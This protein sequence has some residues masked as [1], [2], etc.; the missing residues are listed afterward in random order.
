MSSVSLFGL[1]IR[2]PTKL[3]VLALGLLLAPAFVAGSAQ[4]A[5]SSSLWSSQLWA[6]EGDAAARELERLRFDLKK[7]GMH[8]LIELVAMGSNP[9]KAATIRAAKERLT[10]DF[11]REHQNQRNVDKLIQEI[12]R[13]D[14]EAGRLKI[15]ELKMDSWYKGNMRD[16]FRIKEVV[17][18]R[19]PLNNGYTP[20]VREG[21]L[22][23]VGSLE[24]R[25][26]HSMT[27]LRDYL[28]N[29]FTNTALDH[30]V[31]GKHPVEVHMGNVSETLSSLQG[32][33]Y[34]LVGEVTSSQGNYERLFMAKSPSGQVT[35]AITGINGLDRVRH[36]SSLMRYANNGQGVAPENMKIFGDINALKEANY[37]SFRTAL[38]SLG[39]PGK[40]A[41][42]GFRGTMRADLENRA[43]GQSAMEHLVDVLGANP[44]DGL[45]TRLQAERNAAPEAERA[46]FD[47]LIESIK[48]S[49]ALKSGLSLSGQEVF[50]KAENL[51]RFHEAERELVRMAQENPQSKIL[52]ELVADRALKLRGGRSA[53]SY[54]VSRALEHGEFRAEELTVRTNKGQ[55]SLKLINNYYGD[56]MGDMARAL[57]DA[58]YKKVG[59][60][61]TAGGL[62]EGVKIGDVHVPDRIYDHSGK[63]VGEGLN[64]DLI[65]Q[66]ERTG[67]GSL[68]ESIKTGVKLANV[69]SPTQETMKWLSDSRRAGMASVEVENAYLAEEIQRYNRGVSAAEKV[70]FMSSV[71]ISDVPGSE[72]TLGNNNGSTKGKFERMVDH[73]IEAFGIESVELMESE[74]ANKADQR[75]GRN[76][77][78]RK[79]YELAERLMGD[80]AEKSVMR[81]A[82]VAASLQEILTADQ[83]SRA[84]QANLALESLGLTAEQRKLLERQLASRY[85]DRD[86]LENLKRT[87]AVLSKAVAEMHAKHPQ[88]QFELRLGGGIE[89]GRFAPNTGLV[90]ELTG[91]ELGRKQ[92][93]EI[94]KKHAATYG[95]LAPKI[96][97]G[98]VG[99][100]AV[101]VGNGR[102]LLV[103]YGALKHIHADLL[104]S[105]RGVNLHV[106]P[107]GGRVALSYASRFPQTPES[108]QTAK[109]PA[110]LKEIR[111]L[112]ERLSRRGSALEMVKPTDARLK[113]EA[114]RT[115]IDSRGQVKLLVAEGQSLSASRRV[116]E[117]SRVMTF[118]DLITR[119]GLTRT[120]N[121]LDAARNGDPVA[122]SRLQ[123]ADL[124]TQRALLNELPHNSPERAEL[125]RSK[126][127]LENRADPYALL[128]NKRG[129]VNWDKVKSFSKNHGLGV[130]SF[131]LGLFL[132][133]LAKAV[134]S[135]DRATIEAFFD[136]LTHTDFWASYAVFSIGAEVGSAFYGKYLQRFV[137][138][139]FVSNV[140]RANVALASGMLISEL[141]MGHFN[142]KTFAINATG[143]MLSS[144]AVKVGLEG[145]KWVH[146]LKRMKNARRLVTALRLGSAPGWIYSGV[147]TAVVLFFGEKI[148]R[149][150]TRLWDR[151]Q[152]SKRLRERIKDFVIASKKARSTDDPALKAALEE[153]SSAFSAFR[154]AELADA[155]LAGEELQRELAELGTEAMG[156]ENGFVRMDKI[157]AAD[158]SKFEHLRANVERMRRDHDI[159]MNKQAK[160][161]MSRF[162][163]AY[164]EGL[165][166]AYEENQRGRVYRASKFDT[167]SRNRPESFDD[168]AAI[169]EYAASLTSSSSVRTFLRD[170]AA[171]VR[172]VK[173]KDRELL[174]TSKGA[175]R[176]IGD[177]GR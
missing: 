89:L 29:R 41:L 3:L 6:Q 62:A 146:N 139:T 135:G 109:V 175:S 9:D 133:E 12:F 71:M 160:A 84:L 17:A 150:I 67:A 104:L 165:R 46:K 2:R 147:E 169:Y 105:R 158:P 123:R 16:A 68:G 63:R 132:M 80:K 118:Q 110:E 28:A 152:L 119:D 7:E 128:R 82:N 122:N 117:L 137:K 52:K 100:R 116:S 115:V 31:K 86:V 66:L 114:S 90:V 60:F 47:R 111:E 73:Y 83:I 36:L 121:L 40:M 177:I 26:P 176:A 33:G 131:T 24:T 174:V 102:R 19:L 75:P 32:R 45:L 97:L 93:Q 35:Y 120:L 94:L 53:T 155:I 87:N 170:R 11:V 143:L 30:I 8:R 25:V 4:R 126:A 101:S 27:D 95:E 43:K 142:G 171:L 58:G 64:N 78:E 108:V 79:A 72:H 38:E 149:G 159:E 39:D 157:I 88:F 81:R 98:R 127:I 37:R 13:A 99:E 20:P 1:K 113:G 54:T 140:L 49:N 96:E 166:K 10:N 74:K 107:G 112:R 51:E 5:V 154:N 162:Q 156:K 23:E 50:R 153:L 15:S 134:E 167:P 77:A 141:A 148:S 70:R 144:T 85:T 130:A 138:P 124:K 145:I 92:F 18:D 91:S 59:Y 42:I 76:E 57:V 69:F 164:D 173:A 21:Y 22:P 106:T 44:K 34:T 161:A 163:K 125:A 56:V 65:R 103:E 61:G 151:Y 14:V 55:R 136:G 129:M 48:T 172:E 168:E